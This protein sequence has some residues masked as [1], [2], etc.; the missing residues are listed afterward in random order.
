MAIEYNPDG[1]VLDMKLPD[2]P[3]LTVLDRLKESSRTRHIPV[4]VMAVNDHAKAALQMGA[5][6]FMQKPLKREEIKNALEKLEATFSKKINRVLIVEDDELQRKAI[7]CLIADED[8]EITMVALAKEAIIALKKTVFD[9]MIMDLQLPDVSGA[10]L[11]DQMTLEK[12]ASFPP[13]IVYTGVSLSQE[14]VDILKKLSK[15]I[16]IKV[17]RSPEK[18]LDEV[19]LTLHRA[20]SNMA[21]KQRQMIKSARNREQTFAGR[22]ILLVDDD[23]RNIYALTSA[24]EQKWPGRAG[25]A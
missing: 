20:E 6:G 12:I 24:L 8:I 23:I 25:K 19:T 3:G 14:Q 11:L 18:L 4:Q 9:C 1:I 21:E 2:H 10:E 22:K 15:S 13:V 17:A 5:M 7:S 16:I